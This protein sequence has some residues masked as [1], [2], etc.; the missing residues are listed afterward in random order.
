E[1]FAQ[2]HFPELPEMAFVEMGIFTGDGIRRAHERGVRRVSLGCMIGKLSKI[3]AGKMQ[4]HVAG[5]Q[6]DCAFLGRVAVEVGASAELAGAIAAAN[7][8]R[9]VQELI[10]TAGLPVFFSRLCELAVEKCAAVV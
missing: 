10:E 2:R 7:T 8:A 6:V 3:A 9:H 1:K 5:N 4:T